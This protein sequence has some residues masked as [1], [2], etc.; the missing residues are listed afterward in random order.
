MGIDTTVTFNRKEVKTHGEGGQLI[1]TPLIGNTVIIDDVIT[2]GT[3]FRGAQQLIQEHGGKVTAMVIALDPCER[4][5][6]NHST[7]A[8]IQV[9]GIDVYS[10]VTLLDL[11]AY[12]TQQGNHQQAQQKHY[13]CLGYYESLMGRFHSLVLY[14]LRLFFWNGSRHPEL[15]Y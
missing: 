13:G 1:G 8:E 12:L 2:A 3:V 9:Q 6:T 11:I 5:V 15:D 14:Q 4:G 7:L 10:I